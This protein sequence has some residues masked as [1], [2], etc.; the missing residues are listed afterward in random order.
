MIAFTRND[1]E[2]GHGV[3]VDVRLPTR[4]ENRHH[5]GQYVLV[6]AEPGTALTVERSVYALMDDPRAHVSAHAVGERVWAAFDDAPAGVLTRRRMVL[7]GNLF[8]AA[9]LAAANGL[10]SCAMYTDA[11]GMRH[12]GVVLRQGVS[13]RELR[14]LP[15]RVTSPEIVARLL[16]DMPDVELTSEPPTQ[17]NHNTIVRLLCMG[18]LMRLEVP[19]TKTV[20]GKF[21]LDKRLVAL[22]GEFAGTRDKMIARFG[23]DAVVDVVRALARSGTTLYAPAAVRE[24]IVVMQEEFTLAK[25]LSTNENDD[26]GYPAG[27]ALA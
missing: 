14:A 26:M 4:P 23:A 22:T 6:I 24:Q 15:V 25:R 20:G 11:D 5:A 13:E 17:D 7:D 27:P 10:G 8:K 19:G 12:R 2:V 3:V 9:Q 18:G 16:R 21:F 1:G